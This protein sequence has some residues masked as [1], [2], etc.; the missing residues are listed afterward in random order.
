MRKVILEIQDLGG[1][2]HVERRNC[3]GGYGGSVPKHEA[4]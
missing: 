2:R 3:L 1:E 4:G